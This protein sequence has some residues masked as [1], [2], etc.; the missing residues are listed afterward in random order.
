MYEYDPWRFSTLVHS[1]I[2]IIIPIILV[3]P[4][5]IITYESFIASD[6]NN[7]TIIITLT[8]SYCTC[9]V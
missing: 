6:P 5:P 8:V 1:L 9:T 4:V 7:A 3:P 2:I